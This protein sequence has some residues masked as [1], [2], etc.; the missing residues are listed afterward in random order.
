MSEK[1]VYLEG[2]KIYLRS[3]KSEDFGDTM[4]Q[5]VNDKDVTRYLS[6]GAFPGQIESFQ[7]EYK[8][9]K[10]SKTDL[11]L[12][13]CLKEGDKYIG[14]TGLHSIQ[15]IARHA[16]FRILIGDKES[17]G[18]G[19]GTEAAQLMTSYG[20][21]VLNLNRVWL[22]VNE[23]NEKAFKSYLKAGFKEEGKLRQEVFRNG[24]YY[25]VI[26]MSILINEYQE[27]KKTWPLYKLLQKQ[28]HA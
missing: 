3:P 21:E 24:K 2:D 14:V 16:E 1:A 19:A 20:F 15:L 28:L 5:W 6:R 25:D 22:G 13:V 9:L 27:M 17:W 18:Q 4:V 8:S 12:S 26:R 10:N 23:A 7:D 11:Q